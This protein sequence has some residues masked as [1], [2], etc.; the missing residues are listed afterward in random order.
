MKKVITAIIA[1]SLCMALAIPALAGYEFSSGEDT[2]AGFGSATSSDYPVSPDPM[3]QNERRNKDAALLPPPYFYG[4]GD[5]PTDA[6]SLY[7]DTRPGGSAFASA[8][9]G[10]GF[11]MPYDSNHGLAD[12][13][14][15]LN[16]APLYYPDGSIG[17]LYI[18]RTGRTIRVYEGEQLSNLR[19]G[20]GHFGGTSAWDGNVGMCGHNRGSSPFFSFVKDMQIGDRVVYTTLYGTR[21]YEVYSRERIGEYDHSL[22]GWSAENIL[23]LITCIENV[24][25]LRWAARLREVR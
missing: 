7:H 13:T 1:L 2:L 21:T 18:A 10:G 11:S 4:S 17:T 9:I 22:L 14:T 3:T 24:P 6:G 16:T 25:E 19:I 23:T 5:I 20:A 8:S 12:S 15:I